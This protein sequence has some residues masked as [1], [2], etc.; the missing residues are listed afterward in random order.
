M[1][2]KNLYLI[3]GFLLGILSNSCNQTRQQGEKNK[4][5]A[6]FKMTTPIPSGISIPDKVSSRMGTLNFS[7]GFPDD[8]TVEKLYDNL[9]YQRAVQGYL[10]GLPVVNMAGIRRGISSVGP[11]NITIPIF[12]NLMDART[13]WLTA[14]CNTPYVEIWID[15]HDG[16]LVLEVP[17]KVLGAINDSWNQYVADIGMVGAD[18][19][20]GGKYLVL[21][22]GYKGNIP[23]GYIVIRS[24]T[25]ECLYGF[26][27]LA[28][29]GDFKP[30]I[31][32]TRKLTRIYPLS[33]AGNPPANNFVNVSG[34]N[35][36]TVA[37]SD[38]TF[39]EYLN[40]VV[41]R[42]PSESF[43]RV[44]LGYFA[45]IG[46]EKGKP[47][48]P[49][50]RMKKILTEAAAAG[51]ATARAITYKMRQKENYFYENSAWRNVFLGGYKF[52][53]QP[54]VLNLDGYVSFYFGI[55]G[56]TPAE[57][58][59]IIGKGSQYVWAF[60]DSKG[61]SLDGTRDYRLHL[62]AGIPVK[63]FWSVILYDYQTRSFLQ[64]DQ[65]F[66]MV[67]SQNEKMIINADH[68][69]DVYFGPKAPNGKENNWIQTVPG[70]GWFIM[71]RL[72]GPLEPWFDKTWK[73][74]E[75]ELI[76]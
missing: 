76:K 57:D 45:S 56:V 54:N 12:E 21:P 6:M 2:T 60:M 5:S 9:D 39:W 40:E 72:Y 17:P 14:N 62:P 53:N 58:V 52:E 36:C 69:V 51:V 18:K 55:M 23:G 27:I 25:F 33:K 19:G 3:L 30:A 31:E 61:N 28:L 7:D 63:D 47:F 37:P 22:P 49:D 29:P 50:A 48:A 75:I 67:T 4:S 73:P 68:S 59:K 13:L 65:Q 15:L 32:T 64:T 41:Q 38:Y 35:I 46:I 8:A 16:P 42:E 26:R 10:L 71:L 34:K 1:K 43:D 11:P 24:T 44:S 20:E 66:P 70:K 74:G